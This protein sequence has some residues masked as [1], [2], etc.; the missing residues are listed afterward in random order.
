MSPTSTSFRSSV[1]SFQIKKPFRIKL[2]HPDLPTQQQQTSPP[3]QTVSSSPSG[4]ESPQIFLAPTTRPVLQ[5]PKITARVRPKN[6]PIDGFFGPRSPLT[7]DSTSLG[8]NLRPS[9]ISPIFSP[10]SSSD[11]SGGGS[12]GGLSPNSH[13]QA[14]SKRSSQQTIIPSSDYIVPSPLNSPLKTQNAEP[15]SP[16]A[17]STT[18][19]H[20]DLIPPQPSPAPRGPLPT[21]PSSS[22][23]GESPAVGNRNSSG[24]SS[25]SATQRLP[26]LVMGVHL[27]QRIGGSGVVE[28][29]GVVG[30]RVEKKS[31]IGP[32]AA[33]DISTK[34][35]QKEKGKEARKSRFAAAADNRRSWI[36]I[37]GDSS[38]ETLEVEEDHDQEVEE[39]EPEDL[40]E[41]LDRFQNRDS[42]ENA[43]GHHPDSSEQALERS[44][45]FKAGKLAMEKRYFHPEN[46]ISFKTNARPLPR[47]QPQPRQ[48]VP[49][50]AVIPDLYGFEDDDGK[51]VGDRT[52]RWTE[53]VYSR[54]S[55]SSI[56]DEEESE[57]RRGRFLKRVEAMLDA[58]KNMKAQAAQAQAYIPPLPEIPHAYAN[59]IH[60]KI[61][62]GNTNDNAAG[63]QSS[64]ITPGRSWNKF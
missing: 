13:I 47:P 26:P 61:G 56:L 12:G 7:P 41:I 53:S 20:H 18:Y 40:Y 14:S 24:G 9:P 28:K 52:S 4:L 22:E 11:N 5:I 29:T 17:V 48:Y 59:I 60:K 34:Y 3:A 45:S 55:S 30:L 42:N 64:N 16:T 43:D 21:P 46:N 8:S 50:A 58:E 32:S 51:S 38:S 2:H 44:H 36:D 1:S 62:N 37:D 19:H 54:S 57:E 33:D 6:P 23:S 27:R 39:E 35:H 49:A 10:G 63:H 25:E 31:G 15:P